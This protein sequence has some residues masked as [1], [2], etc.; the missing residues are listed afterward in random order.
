MWGV[1][2]TRNQKEDQKRKKETKKTCLPV[3]TKM[4]SKRGLS[5][6]QTRAE[7][8]LTTATKP[9]ASAMKKA[10]SS[11]CIPLREKKNAPVALIDFS[12]DIADQEIQ[13]HQVFESLL[14]GSTTQPKKGS[15]NADAL[16]VSNGTQPLQM[17]DAILKHYETQRSLVVDLRHIEMFC[18]CLHEFEKIENKVNLISTTTTLGL[19]TR[20]ASLVASLLKQTADTL[21]AFSLLHSDDDPAVPPTVASLVYQLSTILSKINSLPVV[22]QILRSASSASSSSSSSKSLSD[23]E[24]V[25]NEEDLNQFVFLSSSSF[26]LFLTLLQKKVSVNDDAR[27]RRHD[28]DTRVC[29]GNGH[30]DAFRCA[31]SSTS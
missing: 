21:P 3:S 2:E 18:T 6:T 31:I 14:P 23:K 9:P 12:L 11:A 19:W 24:N 8:V 1:F 22:L 28:L 20:C 26:S 5:R 10:A 17:A 7:D 13:M 4:S 16:I 30:Q 15:K 25:H 29:E 27:D